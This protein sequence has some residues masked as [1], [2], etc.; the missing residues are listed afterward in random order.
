MLGLGELLDF[1]TEADRKELADLLTSLINEGT[2]KLCDKPR[3]YEAALGFYG[4]WLEEKKEAQER[5]DKLAK[6]ARR[7]AEEA[8]EIKVSIKLKSLHPEMA[9]AVGAE[10]VCHTTLQR[11]GIQSFLES[12][13]WS[14]E[15]IDV[16]LMQI[17][18]RAVYPYSEF[19]TAKY[20]RE[21]SAV[22]KMFP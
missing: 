5:A 11:L 19:K 12:R 1:P 13:G 3:L 4:K 18:A 15:K 8:R 20:I 10:H 14:K 6:E 22:C 21:N 17:I 9:R 2:G 7:K 16:A